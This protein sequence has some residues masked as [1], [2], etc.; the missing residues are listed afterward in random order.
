MLPGSGSSRL[1][2][3]P[4][5]GWPCMAAVKQPCVGAMFG[6]PTVPCSCFA[7]TGL[8]RWQLSCRPQLPALLSQHTLQADKP[9]WYLSSL[10]FRAEQRW[11]TPSRPARRALAHWP[12]GQGARRATGSCCE[13]RRTREAGR[14][15]CADARCHDRML[16][17]PPRQWTLA[18]FP[19]LFPII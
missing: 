8:A 14:V 7:G 9:S 4:G 2:P 19:W 13:L 3:A 11:A 15:G 16:H 17:H 10:A 18:A 1:G 6:L 12:A 5:L